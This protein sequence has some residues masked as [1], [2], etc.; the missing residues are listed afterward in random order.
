MTEHWTDYAPEPVFSTSI[1]A[2]GSNANIFAIVG[3]AS[4]MLREIGVPPDRIEKLQGDVSSA[5][6]Y[7]QA[8][9]FVERWFPV[10]RGDDE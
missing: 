1:P 2:T 8:I 5:V 6:S 9:S 7:D 4:R 10:D 3:T